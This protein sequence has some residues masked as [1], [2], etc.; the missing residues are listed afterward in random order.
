MKRR[1]AVEELNE[2]TNEQ[3]QKLREL[4]QPDMGDVCIRTD[5][6]ADGEEFAIKEYEPVWKEH[7]FKHLPLLDI[8]QMLELLHENG[9]VRYECKPMP[10]EVEEDGRKGWADLNFSLMWK[11]KRWF[12]R[13][14]NGEEIAVDNDKLVWE[15]TVYY[16]SFSGNSIVFTEKEMVDALW[17]VVKE[18]LAND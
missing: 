9:Y 14:T 17:S 11:P 8:S 16:N 6:Y 2:L 15:F 1:I 4:W 5:K 12:W 13:N 10:I 7:K 18:V 3:K